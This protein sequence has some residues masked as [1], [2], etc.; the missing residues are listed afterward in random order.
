MAFL[1]RSLASTALIHQHHTNP[2]SRDTTIADTRV[3]S[4]SIMTLTL[5]GYR[6]TSTTQMLQ[7]GTH[8]GWH[9][10]QGIQTHRLGRK[11]Q[12]GR[13]LA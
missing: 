12:L 11:V 1:E 8:K 6:D 2:L 9:I 3:A 13:D 10:R 4:F 7:L 5:A